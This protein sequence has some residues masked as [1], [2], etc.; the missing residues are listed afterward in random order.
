VSVNE[1]FVERHLEEADAWIGHPLAPRPDTRIAEATYAQAHA[2][3]AIAY[4]LMDI[5][6]ALIMERP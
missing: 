5:Y 4:V 6:E 3:I 1:E 2:T